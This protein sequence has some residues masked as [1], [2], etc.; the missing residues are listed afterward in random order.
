MPTFRKTTPIEAEQF[1]GGGGH[2]FRKVLWDFAGNRVEFDRKDNT[3]RVRTRE[4]WTE[5]LPTGYW[6]ATDGKS[7]WPVADDFMRENYEEV[8]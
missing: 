6:V 3:M 2:I 4:G 8:T 1:T 7:F 5:W